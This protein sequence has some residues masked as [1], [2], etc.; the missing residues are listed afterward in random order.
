MTSVSKSFDLLARVTASTKRDPAAVSGI[1]GAKVENV[2]S[3]AIFALA[4]LDQQVRQLLGLT[5]VAGE[6]WQTFTRE[7]DICEGDVL[8]VDDVEY[9]IRAVGDWPWRPSGADRVVVVVE[10][11][12]TS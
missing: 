11:I 2:A 8:V 1:I 5:A 7:T 3:V 12:K 10:E 6:L 9:P 4:P